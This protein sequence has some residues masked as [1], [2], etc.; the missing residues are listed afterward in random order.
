MNIKALDFLLTFKCNAHCK[1]CCYRAGPER[2]GYIPSDRAL[3]WM[4]ELN[5]IHPLNG[6]TIHGGEPFLYFDDMLIIIKKARELG[7]PQRWVITNAYWAQDQSIVNKK[8][9]ALKDAGITAITFS[10][11]AFHQEHVPLKIIKTAIRSAVQYDLDTV[12]IDSYFLY[13]EENDCEYNQKTHKYVS[14]LNNIQNLKYNRFIASIEGR[15]ASLLVDNEY[16][17]EEI[18]SGK[19]NPPFWL[20][21]S[22][23]NPETIEIDWQGNI[24]LC[25]GLSLGNAI[26]QSLPEIIENYNYREHPII[27][28]IVEKGPIGLYELAKTHGYHSNKKFVDE[29]HLCYEMRKYLQKRFPEYMA[30]VTCYD[31]Y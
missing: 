29:C 20:G 16:T 7:I 12:V 22:L 1:H 8:L 19:C 21:S 18:P 26:K 11:D 23:Q 31:E 5:N 9:R 25:P 15:A 4:G 17:Q 28:I 6:I 13:N 24:T 14:N 3:E 2:R 27:K 30:P 10:V